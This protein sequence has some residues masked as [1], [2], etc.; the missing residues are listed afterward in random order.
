MDKTD[1]DFYVHGL[2]IIGAVGIFLGSLIAGNMEW[3]EG[4]TAWTYGLSVIV[5]FILFLFGGAC[6]ISAAV[7]ARNETR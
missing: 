2:L 6:W 7:N 4:T 3:V 5:A 1:F